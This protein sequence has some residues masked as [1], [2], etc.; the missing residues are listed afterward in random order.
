MILLFFYGRL[1]RSGILLSILEKLARK[2]DCLF[3]YMQAR[4]F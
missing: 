4:W 3:A 2:I 1:L